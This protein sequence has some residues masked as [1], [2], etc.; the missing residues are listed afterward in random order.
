MFERN[1]AFITR[2]F[3]RSVWTQEFEAFKDSNEETALL[4]QLTNWSNRVVRGETADEA[5]LMQNVF[6]DVW[7][8]RD[9][10]G[11]EHHTLYPQHPVPGAGPRGGTRSADAGLG[12]FEHE[13]VPPVMQ[14][15]CEFK[16]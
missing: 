7:G 11:A 5:A 14:V 8:Y 15:A 16:P 2:A 13:G 10:G 9:T 6:V 4:T 12:F 1:P 3:L